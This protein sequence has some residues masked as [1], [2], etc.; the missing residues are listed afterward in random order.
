MV[1]LLSFQTLRFLKI[2]KGAVIG[3]KHLHLI[4]WKLIKRIQVLLGIPP[5]SV[6]YVKSQI[7][8]DNVYWITV[9]VT[10]YFR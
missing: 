3:V 7:S 4:T 8:P 9:I 1:F 10:T 5:L 2:Q 6:P